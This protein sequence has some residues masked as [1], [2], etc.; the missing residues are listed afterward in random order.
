MLNRQSTL[1]LAL[2]ALILPTSAYGQDQLSYTGDSIV[3]NP[4]DACGALSS[5]SGL[6]QSFSLVDFPGND[7]F[8]RHFYKN[9]DFASELLALR[10]AEVPEVHFFDDSQS[11]NAWA[12]GSP[13]GEFHVVFGARLI[14]KL[15]YSYPN[16]NDLN[17]GAI[18][19]LIGHEFGHIAQYAYGY[20]GTTKNMELMADAVSGFLAA[21]QRNGTSNLS[22]GLRL[23][24]KAAYESGDYMYTSPSHHGTPNERL[25]AFK[26]GYENGHNYIDNRTV[27]SGAFLSAAARKFNV[28][29]DTSQWTVVE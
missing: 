3:F 14:E 9:V 17:T 7:N 10:G 24:Q 6:R 15:A 29:L 4:G 8:R 21:A 1:F 28:S 13:N 16:S 26:Y 20:T 12:I 27:R 11:P 22:L 25:D 18:N 19:S 23:S 2:A 5:N